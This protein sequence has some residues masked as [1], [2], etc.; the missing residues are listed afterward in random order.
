MKAVTGKQMRDLDRKAIADFGIPGDVL[1]DRAGHGVAE[2]VQ[3]LARVAGYDSP[4]VQLIAGRGNNG[5]DAFVAARYLKERGYEVEVWL[6]AEAGATT[7]DALKHLSR[8]KAAK[9]TLH[10]LPTKGDWDDEAGASDLS[11]CI[12][13]DGILGTGLTGPARGPAAGAISYINALASRN[14]VVAIDV[15]SGLNSDTGEAAGDVV[16]ADITATIGLPKWGLL[17]PRA[18]EYVGSVEVVDIGLPA[19]LIDRVPSDVE[20][21]AAADLRAILGRRP[22][23]AHKGMFGHVL[24]I[25]GAPGYAGAVALA[26]EA[27]ARSGAGLVTAL[28]PAGIAGVVAG[29]VPEAMVHAGAQTAEGTLAAGCLSTWTRQL[30]DFNAVLMGP[31]MTPHADT[32]ALVETVL[33]QS[34][35][36]VL[37]DADALNVCA[38]HL[39]ILKQAA[40]RLLIT[41]HPGEMARLTG[42]RV[43]DVQGD[44]FNV[45]RQVAEETSAVTVLK[46][47]GTVVAEKGRPLNVNLTGNP[48]MA[49]GGMG[50][51]L[52]GLTA[53][54]VAQGLA[55]FDAARAGV[56]LHGRAGD[57]VAW[58]TSQAGMI[59][60]DV[61]GELPSIFREIALR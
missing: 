37:L 56:Y 11:G 60:G 14:L 16:V 41:P 5:G 25:G 18:V 3:F 23:H 49:S 21:I 48:G 9:I 46:G 4:L 32:R 52:S 44:R 29:M 6:A 30:G 54:L 55:P 40:G 7:G 34:R 22:R 17:D 45:A 43:E 36:P 12:L 57:N 19:E 47:A 58:R 15:P 38:G 26:A 50:D 39:D 51:V 59:A 42:M 33:A 27:A 53:G 1:M 28:V 61:I 35:A 10:E 31:G 8:L 24:I 2:V 20:L 13:V